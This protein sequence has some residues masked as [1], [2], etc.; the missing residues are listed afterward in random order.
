M[1]VDILSNA[2]KYFCIHSLFSKAFQHIKSL[3]LSTIEVGKY[4]IEKENL[5]FSVS[6]KIGRSREESVA[7]FE[8][9]N[10]YIDIQICIHGKE[11]IGW[12][13]RDA[14]VLPATYQNANADFIYYHDAPDM[15]FE[16]TNNQFAIFFPGDVHA[17]MIG[18]GVIKKIVLK[19][20]IEEETIF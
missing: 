17:P 19:V 8:C 9:H 12:K 4:E 16:L 3:D 10:K 14:C 11:Q 13:P 15:Y 2:E 7:R 1:I 5:F 20:K 18:E 6:D